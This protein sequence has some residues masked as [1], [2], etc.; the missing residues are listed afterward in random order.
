MGNLSMT[1]FH[2]GHLP[3]LLKL[4]GQLYRRQ[5]TLIAGDFFRRSP[6]ST[7][8]V[9][10]GAQ[11]GD[12]Q[13]LSKHRRENLSQVPATRVSSLTAW[14]SRAGSW[15]HVE[16]F[17]ATRFHLQ[18]RLTLSSHSPSVLVPSEPCKCIFLGFCLC[19][20][21]KQPFQRPPVTSSPPQAL[22]V[23]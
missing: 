5:K 22:H 16:H 18:P 19:R 20:P 17:L 4:S 14:T 13:V 7:P 10:S 6:F 21:S 9:P 1:V 12:L 2:S 23:S 15:G 3:H 11:G 8:T